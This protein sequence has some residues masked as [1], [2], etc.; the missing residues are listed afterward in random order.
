[1]VEQ[2]TRARLTLSPPL[3]KREQ[4]ARA[5]DSSAQDLWQQLLCTKFSETHSKNLFD[6]IATLT[7][8]LCTQDVCNDEISTLLACRLVP[9]KKSDGAI[10]PV[11][12]GEAL[13]IIMRKAA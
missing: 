13:R 11:G 9:L 3:K 5:R 8:R 4:D 7:K 10:R 6:E 1:M 2:T 12:I